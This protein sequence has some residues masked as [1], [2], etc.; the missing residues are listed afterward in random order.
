MKWAN[1]LHIYQPADQI[2]EILE[3]VA[4]ES[5]RPLVQSLLEH[6]HIKL[7]LNINAALSEQLQE[8][9]YGDVIAGLR[10]AAKRG[11]IEFTDTAKYHALLPFLPEDELRR[12]IVLNRAT[13]QKIFGHVYQPVG[14]F[15]PEMAYAPNLLPVL[16]E[17]GYQWTIIDEIGLNGHVNQVDTTGIYTIADTKLYIFFR[18][19]NPS[20]LVMSALVRREQDFREIMKDEY[21]RKNYMI[22]GMDGE[23]FGHHRPGLQRLL[24]DLLVSKDMEHVFIS[25]LPALFSKRT[26][27][28]P[29]VST[30]AST[31]RDIENDAQFLTWKDKGNQVH[32][33]QWDFQ[34]LV[35]TAIKSQNESDP[36][37]QNAR[38]KLDRA[39]ASDQFFWAS[40]RP[41]WSLEVVE[42]GA[43]MLLDTI[44]SIPNIEE[45]Q[46]KQAEKYYQDIIAKIFEWQRTG[47]IRSIYRQYKEAVR[48][49]FQTRT[50][51]GGEPWVYDAFI[52]LMQEAMKQAAQKENF[53]EAILWRDAIW[54]METKNDIYDAIH[55]VDLLRKQITNA[56]ILDAI[57]KHRTAY[58]RLSS[59]QPEQRGN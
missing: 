35:L 41:W 15:P 59:G 12:Q 56:Q 23:T 1:F 57:G 11:Q 3:K 9:G 38:E 33:W 36:D 8:R 4:N 14:F 55:A 45:Q 50:K 43:W 16:E 27:I 22:T 44:K 17:L 31:E 49:P 21:S 34:A 54:K 13:N 20:N 48:I 30:W 5:Y 2:E 32:S 40:A 25:E 26:A 42:K 10:T 19:R 24:T 6:P 46:V 53:E 7:T 52:E 29:V 58:E 18:E 28:S 47:Y 39:L 37:I 51:E